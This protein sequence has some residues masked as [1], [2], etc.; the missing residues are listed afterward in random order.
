[1][2]L[3]MAKPCEF[4]GTP[5]QEQGRSHVMSDWSRRSV[6]VLGVPFDNVTMREAID[7]MEEKIE[8]RGF[9]QVAT[10]NVDF[11][12]NA[13]HDQSLQEMLCSCD[14]IVPDGMPIV[15]ASRLMGAK[16]KERVSGIDL[17]PRL[18]E[19]AS[20]RH[21]GI[22]LLGASERSSRRAAEA[23]KKRFPKLRVVGR[24]SPPVTSLSE[25]DHETILNRIEEAKPDILLV[26]MGHPK[27]ERWLA[28]HRQRLKVPLCMGVG[29]SLDFLAGEFSR[30]P[31]WMQTSG[32]E[33]LYRAA[34][35]PRRLVQRYMVDAFGLARHLPAQV[36]AHAIQPRIGRNPTVFTDRQGNASIISICGNLSGS[37]II[38]F[39]QQLGRAYLEDRHIVLDLAKTTYF[40]LDSLGLLVHLAKK[41]N[42]RERQIWLTAV[43][44][45]VIRVFRAARMNRYFGTTSTISD[46]IYRVRKSETR[47]ASET[48]G[49]P[50]FANPARDMHVQV[51]VLKDLC[52]KIVFFSQST[53]LATARTGTSSSATR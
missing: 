34:Q 6:A 31:I 49:V 46:A 48:I 35:E 43:P 30:A 38:E 4:D 5:V 37:L 1:M 53:K 50:T 44:A 29:A 39:E 17:I 24:H 16:L 18:A 28:M 47:C 20:R 14:L 2:G 3:T 22:Y 33:W 25:M 42:C 45:H 13:I 12:I 51:Q 40:G 11:V 27:Q 36:A 52:R 15:W 19:L 23:L 9:H 7:V 32:L 21:Y 8:E 10:A 26:A 41:M